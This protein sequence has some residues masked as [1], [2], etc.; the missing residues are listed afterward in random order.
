MSASDFAGRI[1]AALRNAEVAAKAKKAAQRLHDEFRAGQK[2]D[3]SPAEPIWAGPGE[4]FQAFLRLLRGPADDRQAAAAADDPEQPSD[5][6]AGEAST[7]STA[8]SQVDWSKVTSAA[9]ERTGDVAQRMRAM[10]DQ[11]DWARLQPMAAKASSAMIAAVAS[12]QLGVGGRIGAVVAKAIVDQGGLGQQ[13]AQQMPVDEP[14]PD[15]RN[16][17]DTTAR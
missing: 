1:G 13:V 17:I 3:E 12:G 14:L 4:Q 8:L 15:Y 11:V 6:P 16:V 7:V 5:N 10:A 2:G 9:S